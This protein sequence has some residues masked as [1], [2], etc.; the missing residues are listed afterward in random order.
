MT[1]L[2]AALKSVSVGEPKSAGRL[3]VFPLLSAGETEPAYLMLGEA[4][5][6]G[7]V[8][9][10]EVSTS[11][12]V[13]ELRLENRAER[14]VLV[15]DGEALIGAKQNRIVNITILVPSRTAITIPVS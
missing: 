10:T 1:S 3:T 8:T 4:F 7:Q 13:P 14:P 2:S 9:V 5:A 11:G 12:S 6:A 15:V